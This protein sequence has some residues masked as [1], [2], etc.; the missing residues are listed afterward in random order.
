MRQRASLECGIDPAAAPRVRHPNQRAPQR[1]RGVCDPVP[2]NNRQIT[3]KRS[4][5]AYINQK[6][7]H[8][9]PLLVTHREF[10]D[11]QHRQATQHRPVTPGLPGRKLFR[12]STRTVRKPS[13]DSVA[14][15]RGAERYVFGPAC[16]LIKAA[17]PF[18]S[19]TV[20]LAL[21]RNEHALAT[22]GASIVRYECDRSGCGSNASLKMRVGPSESA[23]R[24]WLQITSSCVGQESAW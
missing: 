17:W 5:S 20:S 16:D 13:R 14:A 15:C 18:D 12:A 4:E 2:T 21:L 1:R 8:R 9:S 19:E 23:C 7:F 22:Q 3:K 11:G 10:G 24:S 6:D